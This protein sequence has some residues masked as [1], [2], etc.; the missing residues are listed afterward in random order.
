MRRFRRAV[1]V[2]NIQVRVE[3]RGRGVVIDVRTR[4]SWLSGLSI[5]IVQNV[6]FLHSLYEYVVIIGIQ[7]PDYSMVFEQEGKASPIKLRLH[8]CVELA[9]KLNDLCLSRQMKRQLWE[10]VWSFCHIS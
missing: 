4:R 1:R 8:M 9:I 7:R 5:Y 6:V 10:T 3:E 2:I